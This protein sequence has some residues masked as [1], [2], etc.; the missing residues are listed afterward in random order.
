MK[1][2]V[3]SVAY[4]L[5]EVGENAVGGS[6][7][8][9]NLLDRALT[10]A[11]HCS[12]VIAAE[13]SRVHGTLI[14]S[15][16]ANGTLNPVVRK[17][18]ERVHQQLIRDTLSRYS[19][20]LVHMHSLDFH[21]YLPEPGTPTLATLH[22]PPDWYPPRIFQLDRQHFYLNCVSSSQERACPQSTSL[23]PSIPNGVDVLRLHGR[24]ARRNYALAL[25]R[26]CPE[27]GFHFALDAAKKAGV[28]MVLGGEVFPYAAHQEY[29]RRKI[30]PRLDQRRQFIG[31]VR[32]NTKKRLL[33]EAK[34]LLIPSTVQ[35]T[36]SLVAMEALAAGTPVIA[37]PSGAL[38]EIVEHGRTGY[39]VSNV[40]EMAKAIA[41]VD[42]LDG[43]ECR[44]AA[45]R[46]FSAEIMWERYAQAYGR[47]ISQKS[48]GH[49]H[50]RTMSATSW[51]VNW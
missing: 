11:G 36:S 39:L 19:V 49:E 1:Y 9:L 44:N 24:R 35:E 38:P 48:A 26:I 22:L 31:P 5:T 41:E 25:G 37:F 23:L 21:C 12:L 50:V 4:P 20:D 47:I 6:E 2:T 8:V 28:D 33:L 51:L 42:K 27:K 46:R 45:R 40:R 15:P 16:A 3:L 34:C 17:W 30:A 14:P 7:Q 18:G 43:E 29:F 32:F 13:G 10:D